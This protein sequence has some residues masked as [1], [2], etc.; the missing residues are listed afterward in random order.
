MERRY[1]RQPHLDRFTMRR[2]GS[3]LRPD[4]DP[5]VNSSLPERQRSILQRIAEADERRQAEQERP[6]RLKE[7][8]PHLPT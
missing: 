6:S 7:V 1:T 5:L 8:V 4:Y 2:L 3:A